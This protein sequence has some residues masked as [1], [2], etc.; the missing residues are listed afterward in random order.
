M[1][2]APP[3]P[4]NV[5]NALSG[6]QR[7]AALKAAIE[8]ALF[9][10]IGAGSRSVAAIAERC[11]AAERG[12]RI[13]CDYLVVAGFLTKS[14]AEYGLTAESAIFLDRT[15]PGY[16]GAAA[17]FIASPALME[18]FLADP[19][20]IVRRGGTLQGEGSVSADN[21]IWVAFARAMGPMIAQ[22]AGDLAALVDDGAG[23]PIKVLD[24]A[25][26]HGLFGIAVANRNRA[27][28]ITAL[29]WQAV[30]EVARENA[31]AAGVTSRFRTIA[32][33]AFEVELG[34]PY[35]VVLLTNFLH[36]FDA[37]TCESLLRKVHASLV[38]GG[39]TA[40]LEFVPNEDRVTPPGAA[41]FSFVMLGSTRAG[42]AYTFAEYRRMLEAA[43]F[44]DLTLHE[45]PPTDERVV[46]ARR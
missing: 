10:A 24:I 34:G 45:L 32:G 9:T 7:T 27:A 8:L 17:D 23:R 12:V 42:D 5:F 16:V 19:A 41:A 31:A 6:Y 37:A 13:L 28:E 33:S 29:D 20:G 1:T 46:M 25:A 18:L 35:D 44:G 11:N 14:G 26:G 36:H 30:L 22:R 3:S 21:P 38:P 4:V 43:G 40:L 2:Q 39:R 15:S